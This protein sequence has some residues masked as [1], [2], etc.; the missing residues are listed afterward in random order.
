[1]SHFYTPWKR[2]KTF[3][4]L[5]FSVG[6]EMEHWR[7]KG[8]WHN[9]IIYKKKKAAYRVYSIEETRFARSIFVWPFIFLESNV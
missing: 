2:Q 6:I 4:F 5:T 7:E 3:S 9:K 1:M 8:Y